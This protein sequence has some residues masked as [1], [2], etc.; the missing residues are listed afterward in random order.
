MLLRMILF[1]LATAV[2]WAQ[3]EN[4]PVIHKTPAGR[5]S[6]SSGKQM[7]RSYCA[8]CHG[9]DGKGDGPAS[10]ALKSSP[11]DLTVLAKRNAGRFPAL[12][13]FTAINGDLHVTAHG[14]RDMP[15]WGGVFEQMQ[16]SDAAGVKLRIRNLTKY[17]ESLQVD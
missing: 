4:Q 12:R 2:L 17:I 15:T 1:S 9:N 3:T 8:A 5:T 10:A 6:A 13:V 16:G 14:S 7:Y 11:S